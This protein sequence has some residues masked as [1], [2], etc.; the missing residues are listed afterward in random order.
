MREVVDSTGQTLAG[1]DTTTM[2]LGLDADAP[3]HVLGFNQQKRPLGS[4]NIKVTRALLAGVPHPVALDTVSSNSGTR[5]QTV[6]WT[7]DQRV[8]GFCPTSGGPQCA[9]DESPI[10]GFLYEELDHL[11]D[12]PNLVPRKRLELA[13]MPRTLRVCQMDLSSE[14]TPDTPQGKLFDENI[15]R[16]AAGWNSD[17]HDC[18]PDGCL[19]VPMPISPDEVTASVLI[20]A[21]DATRMQYVAPGTDVLLRDLRR[22]ALQGFSEKYPCLD[23]RATCQRAYLGMDT[24]ADV[25]SGEIFLPDSGVH[26][27][28]PPGFMAD[29][30][31][32]AAWQ[33]SPVSGFVA[34][35][36]PIECPHNPVPNDTVID[37]G[38]KNVTEQ[39]CY[40]DVFGEGD[41]LDFDF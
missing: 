12:D 2:H 38:A 16:L 40:G 3:G 23:D 29:R 7:A 13:P 35:A 41:D 27:R 10:P 30:H 4:N 6:Q 33:N 17:T 26:F 25:I 31:V 22:W 24:H 8:D 34:S 5:K 14:C 9:I 28:F 15:E 19:D 37:P 39:F 18:F 20:E 21:S 36:G 1:N 11:G 32:W